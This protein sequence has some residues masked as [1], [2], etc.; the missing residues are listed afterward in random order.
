[1]SNKELFDT[2]NQRRGDV[3]FWQKR[4]ENR[5][6]DYDRSRL[7]T[8]KERLR[9]AEFDLNNFVEEKRIPVRQTCALCGKIY[10]IDFFVRNDIWALAMP[11]RHRHSL[12]CLECFVNQADERM[13]E[14]DE[15]IEIVGFYSMAKQIKI[16]SE[17]NKM[18]V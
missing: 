1:M 14:W 6:T 18:K 2:V 8:A 5:K 4:W 11:V 9:D 13:I 17:L 7:N 3:A 16:I 12:C 10:K 15:H